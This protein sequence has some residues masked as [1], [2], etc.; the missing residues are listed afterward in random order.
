MSKK[1]E[2]IASSVLGMVLTVAIGVFAVVVAVLI[3]MC[4]FVWKP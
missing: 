4:P 2:S 3:V 1:A